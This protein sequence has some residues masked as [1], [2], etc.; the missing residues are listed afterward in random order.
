MKKVISIKLLVICLLM[1]ILCAGCVFRG[2][3]SKT[4]H[5]AKMQFTD[6]NDDMKKDLK[7]T[8]FEGDLVLKFSQFSLERGCFVFQLC[9]GDQVEAESKV[10]SGDPSSGE[11]IFSGLE[12]DNE[13]II[14]LF[15]EDAYR[16]CIQVEW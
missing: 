15:A 10:Y 9:L 3:Y 12:K 1:M 5:K 4:E 11:I 7:I 14:N 8:G 13:Y 6:Y 16:G 2:S